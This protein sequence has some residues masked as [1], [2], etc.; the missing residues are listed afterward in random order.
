M[1]PD[2]EEL[3]RAV[4]VDGPVHVHGQRITRLRRKDGSE[5]T[6]TVPFMGMEP[7]TDGRHY[8]PGWIT[9]SS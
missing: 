6:V 8:W 3:P 5:F 1:H 2:E 9:E 4:I 7:E